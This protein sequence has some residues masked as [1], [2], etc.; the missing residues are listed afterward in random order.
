VYKNSRNKYVE[1][2]DFV[3]AW[4]KANGHKVFTVY[5]Q[6]A[7]LD[8]DKSNNKPDNLLSLCPRCHSKYDKEYKRFMKNVKL[9]EIKETQSSSID[10]TTLNESK[11]I[12]ELK[13]YIKEISGTVISN[14][15]C[16]L[17]LG[18]VTKIK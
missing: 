10:Y 12:K 9:K 3:E 11:E 8:Q 5:L 1:C 18:I 2:D 16:Q 17:I 14:K 7:H 15:Q 4:A 6:V 13:R